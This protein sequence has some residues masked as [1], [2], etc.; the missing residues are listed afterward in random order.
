[1]NCIEKMYKEIEEILLKEKREAERLAVPV[2]EIK[3]GFSDD[4]SFL[5]EEVKLTPVNYLSEITLDSEW[6][7]K[8][9]E[10][11][12]AKD[13]VL[14]IFKKFFCFNKLTSGESGFIKTVESALSSGGDLLEILTSLTNDLIEYVGEETDE[15]KAFFTNPY[16]ALFKDEN[17]YYAV[18][19]KGKFSDIKRPFGFNPNQMKKIIKETFDEYA[20]DFKGKFRSDK[21]YNTFINGLKAEVNKS[22]ANPLDL[23]KYCLEKLTAVLTANGVSESTIISYVQEKGLSLIKQGNYYFRKKAYDEYAE[24]KKIEF[25]Y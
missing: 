15:I 14:F 16:N 1:M 20:L 8:P 3:H 24:Y 10:D 21:E 25:R 12:R 5:T 23:E 2:R 7:K 11:G 18:I 22:N 9:L 4:A 13:F 19:K 6:D 17:G